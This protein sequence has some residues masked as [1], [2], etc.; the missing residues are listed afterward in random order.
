MVCRNYGFIICWGV[1]N[2][3][4]SAAFA[5]EISQTSP[6]EKGINFFEN[7]HGRIAVDYGS[8]S[9]SDPENKAYDRNDFELRSLRLGLRGNIGQKLRYQIDIKR[10]DWSAELVN[11]NLLYQP[12]DH[13]SV[14]MGQFKMA[15]SMEYQTS[16]SDMTVMERASLVKAFDLERRIGVAVKYRDE[17]WGAKVAYFFETFGNAGDQEKEVI[18]ARVI[19]HFSFQDDVIL[20][21]GASFFSRRDGG[22]S[23]EGAYD[24]SA[25][26]HLDDLDFTRSG[27]FQISSE[28]FLA[29]EFALL[30]GP[31]TVQ[32]EWGCL[33]NT[34]AQSEAVI[35]TDPHYY[36]IYG[37][38]GYFIMGDGRQ[39]DRKKGRLRKPKLIPS[40]LDGGMGS[41]QIVFR[42]DK[43]N[44]EHAEKGLLFGNHQNS[45]IMGANWYLT[46]NTH[47][48]ANYAHSTIAQSDVVQER[49][50]SFGVRLEFSW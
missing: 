41:L 46:D 32:S 28:F 14:Q 44:L 23:Y 29:G 12:T 47:L 10:D 49:I 26:N 5:D 50:N 36:S 31:L 25:Y 21:L 24:Q 20:H 39:Y 27:E 45:Y 35:S 16:S 6:S 43:I 3:I 19:R 22:Q 7:I 4:S 37:E 33:K 11:L 8:L 9:F 17:N 1:I 18:S 42:A 40:V 13:W 48:M 15:N 34:I 30:K 2:I 38:V